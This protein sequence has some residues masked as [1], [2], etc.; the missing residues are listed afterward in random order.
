MIKWATYPLFFAL[1]FGIVEAM[2]LGYSYYIILMLLLYFTVVSDVVY[3]HLVTQKAVTGITMT[4]LIEKRGGSFDV[5]I[6]FAGR[7]PGLLYFRYFDMTA[8][9]LKVGGQN[10]GSVALR[11][12]SEAERHYEVSSPYFGRHKLGPMLVTSS[13]PLGLCSFS[14][15]IGETDSVSV[16]PMIADAFGMRGDPVRKTLAAVGANTIPRAG[17]GYQFLAVR[18]YTI[19]DDFRRIAWNRFG[20]NEGDDVYVKE[21]EDE[22]TTDTI[23]VFDFSSSTDMGQS[24]RIYCSMISSALKAAFGVCKQGDRVGYL[25]YSSSR[26]FFVAPAPVS[27]SARELQRILSSAWPDGDFSLSGAL[28]ELRRRYTKTALTIFMTPLLGADARRLNRDL[29]GTLA[30]RAYRL[31]VPDASSYFGESEDAM[32]T[33]MGLVARG[34]RPECV[35]AVK[36]LGSMGIRVKLSS[37]RMLLPDLSRVWYEGRYSYAGY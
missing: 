29:V 11:G 1:T 26:N 23:F 2:L 17:Q 31:I 20:A 33:L 5:G 21:M 32:F 14:A 6:R 36:S 22:R 28:T 16:P 3:F 7:S 30:G 27:S 10:S 12:R 24:D 8:D 34:R 35:D 9:S 25:L 37:A 13:D 18:P 4:R 19:N 15:W